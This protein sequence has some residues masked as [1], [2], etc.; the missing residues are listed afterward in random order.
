MRV[1]IGIPAY[2]GIAPEF[3]RSIVGGVLVLQAAGDEIELDLVTGCSLIA[4]ARNEIAA[5][6][7]ASDYEALFFLDCD[8]DFDV[9]AMLDVLHAPHAVVGGGYVK[10]D[11]EGRLN[12]VPM[13]PF[14]VDEHGCQEVQRIG[15]GFLRIKRE[16]LEA[17][18]DSVPVADG[19]PQFFQA[20]P[21]NGS[22]WGEDY[23]FCAD[24][25]GIGGKIHLHVPTRLGHIGPFNYRRPA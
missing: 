1:Y 14:V 25:R 2:G 13:E 19:V 7:L 24:Y 15:T 8:M 3:L 4:K 18:L 11:G 16:S 22:Y 20:G 6:F 12:V 17:M 5:R 10:K 23:A 21:R 9:A